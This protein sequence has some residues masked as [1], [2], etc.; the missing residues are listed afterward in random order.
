MTDPRPLGVA[1]VGCG[2]VSKLYYV[3]ALKQLES[4]RQVQVA[5]LF[6]PDPANLA[7][8]H[9]EFPGAAQ[10]RDF[11]ELTGLGLDLAIV[12]SPPQYHA[13][14]TIHLL[15]AGWSVLCEK[16]MALSVAEGE[17]MTAAASTSNR[18]L[19]IGLVRR[20]FP[21]AQT[22]HDIVSRNV[23]GDVLSF[24]C[25]EG[26]VFRWPVQSASYFRDNGVLRDIGV[27]ALDLLTW[28]W[29]LPEEVA[30]EDDAMGGVEVNCRIRLK[31]PQGFR[32]EVCLSR[33]NPLPNFY[34]IQFEKG[35]LQWDID[36]TNRLQ[37]GFVDSGY[38]QDVQLR[39]ADGNAASPADDFR[40]AFVRQLQNV[41][42]AV[43]GAETL[44]VPAEE[45]LR[46]LKVIEQCYAHRTLMEMP[47]LGAQEAMRA[48]QLK[49]GLER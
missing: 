36:E 38:F 13:G 44:A 41:V 28:W 21:A 5:A 16:P 2:A 47:W 18:V 7:Q 33:D 39:R 29:G 34:R 8:I 40:Q 32:G 12:A 35:W 15:Q 30:Y 31:F 37:M 10:V 9:Q 25:Y 46:S 14:Q 3:P 27:H 1:L 11:D 42:S 20:F 6:D 17:A 49:D 4:L 43:R 19:S 48:R 23:L 22:I 24:S 45:G 26:R